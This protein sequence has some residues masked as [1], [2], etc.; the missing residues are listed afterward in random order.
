LLDVDH[1][2]YPYVT[3]SN[4]TAGGYAVLTFR[5]PTESDTASTTKLV[6]TFPKETPIISVSTQPKTGWTAQVATA[7]LPEPKTDDDG[8]K[9]T[10]YVTS[11]TWT[12][13]GPG[14]KPGE[15]DTF[16]VSAGPIPKV[17]SLVFPAAQTYSDGSVVNWDQIAQGDTEPE[18]PAPTV[19]VSAAGAS[20]DA[21]GAAS[22]SPSAE[23][24]A[25]DMSG[26]TDSGAGLGLGIAGLIA[27]VLGLILAIVALIRG[28]RPKATESK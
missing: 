20:T 13:T 25:M 12:A 28:S 14:I 10:T 1:G 9:I 2:T 21:H 5:V 15:F 27:G 16:A 23:A 24:G 19:T 17:D 4:P 6:V 18:H 26:S 3:S 7:N 22:A 11:V 8:N